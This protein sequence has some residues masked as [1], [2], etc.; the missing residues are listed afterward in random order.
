MILWHSNWYS[1]HTNR[2]ASFSSFH[3]CLLSACK[4]AMILF[5][6]WEWIA[7]RSWF[8]WWFYK[9][10]KLYGLLPTLYV[11]RKAGTIKFWVAQHLKQNWVCREFGQK[12]EKIQRLFLMTE[13]Y[14]GWHFVCESLN[15][16]MQAVKMSHSIKITLINDFYALEALFFF[17]RFIQVRFY[18]R[19]IC[20][21]CRRNFSCFLSF[22][23]FFETNQTWL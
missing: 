23:V 9:I 6:F 15:N 22:S 16:C 1:N 11:K 14:I 17:N 19:V 12:C 2:S 3:S 18:F 13:F 5:P 21:T 7:A 10:R 20:S 8:L 4:N